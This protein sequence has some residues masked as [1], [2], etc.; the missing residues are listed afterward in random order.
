MSKGN[1]VAK[2]KGVGNNLIFK[3]KKNSPTILAGVG[4]ASG[5][6]AIIFACKGT[7]KVDAV[8]KEKTEKL[9]KIHKAEDTGITEAGETYTHED[10]KK[11]T[12]MVYTQ[13]ALKY[14]KIFAPAASL[15][16]LSVTSFL[17]ANNILKKRN[18]A[19]SAAYATLDQTFKDY[20]ERVVEKYGENVDR[21][22]RYGLKSE[23]G[24]ETI[25][26][27]NG[28]EKKV[29]VNQYVVNPSNVS[30][31]AR[32]FDRYCEDEDGNQVLNP[33]W[34]NSL[35]YNLFFLSSRERYA[36]DLLKSRKRLF[37][38][39]VYE[40]LGFPKTKAGQVVGWVYD[41]EEPNGD[42]YISF[43]LLD[44][45]IGSTEK[46]YSV[47]FD[48]IKEDRKKALLLDFNVDGNIWDIWDR[49]KKGA[50]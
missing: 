29:K 42:N 3:T 49:K 20:R 9:E 17:A 37:L 8:K 1:L 2:M 34:E 39:D 40:M 25:T 12:T 24:T 7:L 27:E 22:L 23:K 31:Y 30:G 6:A 46:L 13:T 44:N 28:K 11:D 19:I 33:Y 10:A 5:L 35:D 16:A 15:F 43:G 26:D 21:E 50:H 47:Y 32:I 38:N 36:N 14:V 41:P 45:N 4:I 18:V 48:D